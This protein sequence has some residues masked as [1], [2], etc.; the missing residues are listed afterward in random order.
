MDTPKIVIDSDAVRVHLNSQ[1]EPVTVPDNACWR[2]GGKGYVTITASFFRSTDTGNTN[3][4]TPCGAC[5]GTTI[6]P[7]PCPKCGSKEV[8]L[9]T[10]SIFY[11]SFRCRACGHEGTPSTVCDLD[12]YIMW[13]MECGIK[14]K[15]SDL[16]A[17]IKASAA[18]NGDTD[19]NLQL[20]EKLRAK[21]P[22]GP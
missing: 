12:A 11:V 8:K 20:Y 21:Y 17:R 9:F 7:A 3:N 16:L 6:P 18:A 15:L 19:E 1:I 22:E 10:D 4:V 2:C 5:L 14:P 13:Q